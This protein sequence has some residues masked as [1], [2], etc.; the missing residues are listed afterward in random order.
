MALSRQ[1][2]ID[3]L[4]GLK[5]DFSMLKDSDPVLASTLIPT[6]VEL[7]EGLMIEPISHEAIGEVIHDLN[8]AFNKDKEAW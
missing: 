4:E 2:T 7:L 3:A 6:V 5:D 1:K 8:Q